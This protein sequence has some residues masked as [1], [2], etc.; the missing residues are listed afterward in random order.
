MMLMLEYKAYS[1]FKVYSRLKYISNILPIIENHQ[2]EILT[3]NRQVVSEN[4]SVY[5]YIKLCHHLRL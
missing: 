5:S 3:E 2:S 1:L 4:K